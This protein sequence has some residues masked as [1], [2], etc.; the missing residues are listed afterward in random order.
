M[1]KSVIADRPCLTVDINWAN[2]KFVQPPIFFSVKQTLGSVAV[3]KPPE[4]SI[5]TN[6]SRIWETEARCHLDLQAI[7]Y[8]REILYPIW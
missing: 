6:P 7:E 3:V 8:S 1:S 4:S 5:P 2:Q